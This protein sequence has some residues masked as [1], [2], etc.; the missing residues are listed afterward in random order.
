MILRLL[1]PLL[2][3]L[4]KPLAKYVLIPL[5]TAIFLNHRLLPGINFNG[6][7]LIKKNISIPEKV[8]NL[9][10]PCKLNPQLRNLNTDFTLIVAYLDL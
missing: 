6:H 10:I 4:L 8:I 3:T 2:R 1:G 5:T 7:C 9:Y